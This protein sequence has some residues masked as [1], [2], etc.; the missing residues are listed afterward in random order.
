VV[1]AAIPAGAW[2]RAKPF[3]YDE[4]TGDYA[5]WDVPDCVS[6]AKSSLESRLIVAGG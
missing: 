3:G 2:V 1:N 4:Q 5:D 6:P